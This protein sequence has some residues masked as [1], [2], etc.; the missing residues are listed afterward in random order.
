MNRMIATIALLLLSFA[1]SAAPVPGPNPSGVYL[2]NDKVCLVS[3]SRYQV[4]WIQTYLLC[5]HFD[6]RLTAALSTLYA[7]NSCRSDAAIPVQPQTQEDFV[8]LREFNATNQT[9]K[10]IRGMDSGP[11]SN[12]IGFV[13]TWFLMGAVQTNY[14]CS[15]TAA[16]VKP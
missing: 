4:S 7:P 1:A 2:S 8:S 3:I 15:N 6:S 16:R 14:V 9:L 10:V 12:G 11:V 5:L 13:E